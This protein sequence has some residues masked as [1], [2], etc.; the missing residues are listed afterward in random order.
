MDAKTPL[1]GNPVASIDDHRHDIT[2]GF[3]GQIKAPPFEGLQPAVHAS[4]AFRKNKYRCPILDPFRRQG[5][6]FYCVSGVFSF[7]PDI[8]RSR[9]G[10]PEKWDFHEFLFQNELEIHWKKRQQSPDVKKAL[11]VAHVDAR[12]FRVYIFPA[13]DGYPKTANSQYDFGPWHGA[14]KMNCPPRAAK[15]G[16]YQCPDTHQNGKKTNKGI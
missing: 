8:T 10:G 2:A 1:F 3:E 5:D 15:D 12:H 7:N 6:T 11:M 16:N 14:T 4:G 13:A 9:H